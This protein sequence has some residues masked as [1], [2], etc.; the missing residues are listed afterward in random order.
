MFLISIAA[1]MLL[2]G[3]VASMMALFTVLD[4]LVI[5][6]RLD[7]RL[8]EK[9]ILEHRRLHQVCYFLGQWK[10]TNHF[11]LRFGCNVAFIWDSP[12]HLHA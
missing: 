4:L 1:D 9:A 3:E 10:P 7:P 11:A 2:P 5:S 6:D 12:A 8:L